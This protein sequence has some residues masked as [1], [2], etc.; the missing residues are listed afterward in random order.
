MCSA[1]DL[2]DHF[3][4]QGARELWRCFLSGRCRL[5]SSVGLLSSLSGVASQLKS[6]VGKTHTHD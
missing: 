6:G 4:V 5:L 3:L 1:S 2:R